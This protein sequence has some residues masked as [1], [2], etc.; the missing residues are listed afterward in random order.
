MTDADAIHASRARAAA[1]EVIFD[2]HFGAIHA[3]VSRRAGPDLADELAAEAF[4][5]AFRK[6]SRYDASRPD[7]RPWLYGIAANLLARRRRTEER[8]LR[9]YARTG[10]DPAAPDHAPGLHASLDARAAGPALAA[11][12][13]ALDHRDRE[14]LLL[15]AWADLGYAEIAHAL[16]V[17]IGTVRSRL[18]RAR[19]LVRA[20]LIERGELD[21]LVPGSDPPHP[22]TE[23]VP[24]G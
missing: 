10:L 11:A 24:H 3:Y 19:R 14:V 20:E 22:A 13:A 18:S 12:L 17:P 2:R 6:R 7:A 9:A 1:F 23:E 16:S 5:I 21:A 4:A 8:E 15:F